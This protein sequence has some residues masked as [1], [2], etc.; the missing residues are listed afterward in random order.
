VDAG[1]VQDGT[2]S[3]FETKGLVSL[4]AICYSPLWVFYPSQ[5]T[6]DDLSRLIGKKIAIGPE[7]SGVRKFS[8]DLLKA[9]GAA[10]NLTFPRIDGHA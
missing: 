1:F 8:L 2:S 6:W 10:D 9:S 4:G 3:P 5:E 7:G